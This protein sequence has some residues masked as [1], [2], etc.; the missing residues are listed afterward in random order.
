MKMKTSEQWNILA[1]R[2]IETPDGVFYLAYSADKYGNP[3]FRDFVK[4]DKI[5][6]QVAALPQLVE[7]LEQCEYIL[8][9]MEKGGAEN[10][11]LAVVRRALAKAK[12]E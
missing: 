1:G 8:D 10:P 6:Y 11:E 5:A 9:D 7:A 2:C 12:G 3:Y 4:L